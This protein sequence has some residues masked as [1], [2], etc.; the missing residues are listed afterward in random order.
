MI[1]VGDTVSVNDYYY[2]CTRELMTNRHLYTNVKVI[3][4]DDKSW[5]IMV[6]CPDGSVGHF[7]ENELT[8]VESI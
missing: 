2:E 7:N 5:P 6:K 4:V 3:E 8:L 1:K